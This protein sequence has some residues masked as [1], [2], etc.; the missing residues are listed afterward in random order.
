[1]PGRHMQRQLYVNTCRKLTHIACVTNHIN[2]CIQ[3][4]QFCFCSSL[5]RYKS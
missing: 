5:R 1:M 2:H 3:E 4:P